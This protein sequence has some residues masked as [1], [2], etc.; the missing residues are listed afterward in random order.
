MVE[1]DQERIREDRQ[2][3]HGHTSGELCSPD[4]DSTGRS[5]K[6]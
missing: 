6:L 2:R 4:L 3:Q 5:G 1:A